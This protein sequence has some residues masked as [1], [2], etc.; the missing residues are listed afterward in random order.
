MQRCDIVNGTTEVEVAPEDAKMDQGEDK[1]AEGIIPLCLPLQIVTNLVKNSLLISPCWI[2]E[3]GVPSFWL[4]ALKNN[5]IIAE[6]VSVTAT[7][8][9][10][11]LLHP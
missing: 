1:A 8:V 5:D 3:K 2:A 9:H 7:V 6:E 11:E 4:T 10:L